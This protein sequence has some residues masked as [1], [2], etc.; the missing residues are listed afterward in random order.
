MDEAFMGS[1]VL[2]AGNFPPR[3]WAFCN[4]Q[5]LAIASNTALFAILGTTYG[6]DGQTTFKLPDLRGRVPVHAGGSV[7]PGL[8]NV[9]LGEL[10]GS[11]AVTL[12]PK[13]GVAP[14]TAHTPGIVGVVGGGES[15]SVMQPYLGLNYIICTAGLFPSRE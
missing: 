2:F 3:N 9:A 11:R 12:L 7:G 1:I 10:A 13:A 6:G 4:G 8:S 14:A 15:V 5:T